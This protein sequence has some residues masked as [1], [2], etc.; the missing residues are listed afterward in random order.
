MLM[1]KTI[2]IPHFSNRNYTEKG[3]KNDEDAINYNDFC[4]YYCIPSSD[5]SAKDSI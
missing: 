5:Y 1:K 3:D 4:G 2:Y